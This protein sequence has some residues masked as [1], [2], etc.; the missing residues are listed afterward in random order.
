VT[1]VARARD[2]S[3]ASTVPRSG[4][5]ADRWFKLRNAILS[6]P[7]F[8][9]WAARFPLT[10]LVARRR[11]SALFDLCAGFVY[12]QVLQATVRLGVLEALRDGPRT[13]AEL[14]PGL[15]LRPEAAQRL[16]DAAT[17]LKLVER[18]RGGR[19]GL[20][21]HG[22]SLIGN[23]A[24]AR[25][26]EHHALLYRDLADPVAL[27]RG[28]RQ[29]TE[30]GRFWSYAHGSQPRTATEVAGYSELMAASLSLIAEDIL[31][32][33]PQDGHRRLLDVGGGEGAFLEAA[34]ARAPH[35]SL[36][37]FDLPPVAARAQARLA[38]AGLASRATVVGGDVFTQPLP[39]GADLIS[40]VRVIHDHDDPQALRI[41]QAAR[42]ALQPGG[43][44]LV[45]E[46]MAGT[47]G[48]EPMG[49]AYFGFY[50]LAMGQGRPRT[51]EELRA[52]LRQAGFSRVHEARTRRPMLTRLLLASV[53]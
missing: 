15:G 1:P 20:G 35:L 10:R 42:Q 14:A 41:L 6:S 8:Q 48:A 12:A 4:S 9:H 50:L 51:A 53:S 39:T 13:I 31:E 24:V 34:A 32:A 16:L 43:V 22:A 25:M 52:L 23:P 49:D 2:S 40:L 26:V 44:L 21:V 36:V 29:E 18:R 5:L 28:Q 27:L 19:Y 11:A 37:L 47:S 3:P 7:R 30:L 38:R 17:S 45:A 46:P 33:Y